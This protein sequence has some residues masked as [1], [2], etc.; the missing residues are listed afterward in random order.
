MENFGIRLA[1]DNIQI[2]HY[3]LKLSIEMAQTCFCQP[4]FLRASTGLSEAAF[5]AG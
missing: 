1:A 4:P 2:V 5:T 3:P